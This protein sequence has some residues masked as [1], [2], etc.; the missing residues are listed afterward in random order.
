MVPPVSQMSTLHPVFCVYMHSPCSSIHGVCM[1]QPGV[2]ELLALNYR[3]GE[4]SPPAI[5]KMGDND[6]SAKVA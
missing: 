5:Y 4:I 3:L 6:A 2:W 1:H